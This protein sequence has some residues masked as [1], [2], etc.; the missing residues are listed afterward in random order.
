MFVAETESMG[1]ADSV[2]CLSASEVVRVDFTADAGKI[3][4]EDTSP[5]VL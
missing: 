3:P 1:P 5:V 2:K 4:V